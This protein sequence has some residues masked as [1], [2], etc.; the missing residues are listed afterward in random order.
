MKL[1]YALGKLQCAYFR[2]TSVLF[3]PTTVQMLNLALT[4]MKR[5][6]VCGRKRGL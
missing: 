4:E 1:K 5:I 6:T 3:R 2:L